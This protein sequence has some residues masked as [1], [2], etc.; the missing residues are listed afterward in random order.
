V[1]EWVGKG[2][3]GQAEGRENQEITGLKKHNTRHFIHS[4]AVKYRG[5]DQIY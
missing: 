4:Q 3:E 2:V 5:C 1:L